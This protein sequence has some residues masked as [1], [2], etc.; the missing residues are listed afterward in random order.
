MWYFLIALVTT[1][2]AWRLNPATN[3]IYIS[4]SAIF[5][6]KSP[7]DIESGRT[8]LEVNRTLFSSLFSLGEVVSQST[9]NA[10]INALAK[11]L[12]TVFAKSFVD[13]YSLA[14]ELVKPIIEAVYFVDKIEAV[15]A[16]RASLYAYINGQVVDAEEEAKSIIFYN[17]P[18]PKLEELSLPFDYP[19]DIFS[20]K[21]LCAVSRN[22]GFYDSNNKGYE[23][24]NN[25][26][27]RIAAGDSG[28]TLS[29]ALDIS[30]LKLS[31][32]MENIRWNEEASRLFSTTSSGLSSLGTSAVGLGSQAFLTFSN[33]DS[34]KNLTGQAQQGLSSLR[35]QA[36]N[37]VTAQSASA[38]TIAGQAIRSSTLNF[39]KW[40]S[41]G[42]W[43]FIDDHVATKP[44][45]D[46]GKQIWRS[47][48]TFFGAGD[49]S[50][51]GVR[52]RKSNRSLV[53]QSALRERTVR[54]MSALTYGR[55]RQCIEALERAGKQNK[56]AVSLS[57]AGNGT[58]ASVAPVKRQYN[59]HRV[60]KTP[61]PSAATRAIDNGVNITDFNFLILLHSCLLHSM[62][63]Y[64][65]RLS[66]PDR[67]NNVS[68]FG[69]VG[70]EGTVAAS[71]S[72]GT[73]WSLYYIVDRMKRSLWMDG[74]GTPSTR[75]GGR[76]AVM[77]GKNA[78]RKVS[79]L[80]T[81]ASTIPTVV[82]GSGK[83]ARRDRF[84]ELFPPALR[85]VFPPVSALT[86][87]SAELPF[88]RERG[89]DA[90]AA[91]VTELNRNRAQVLALTA[92]G[93]G[94]SEELGDR[95]E[96]ILFDRGVGGGMEAEGRVGTG[97]GMSRGVDTMRGGGPAVESGGDRVGVSK[98]GVVRVTTTRL[99]RDTSSDSSPVLVT[100]LCSEKACAQYTYDAGSR[101]VVIAFRGTKDPVD[102]VTDVTF[103]SSGF[104]ASKSTGAPSLA[105]QN[106]STLPNSTASNNRSG[107]VS[108][109]STSSAATL[110]GSTYDISQRKVLSDFVDGELVEMPLLEVVGERGGGGAGAGA[111]VHR[112]F[113]TA[114]QSLQ[115]ELEDQLR[116]LPRDTKLL[117]TGHSM[118]GALAQI[119]AAHFADRDPFLV[120]FAAPAVGNAQFCA[121]INRRVAPYGGL[122]VWNE[123]DVV[124]Y[125]T[126]FVGYEH[127]GMPLKLKQGRGAKELFQRESINAV[128]P[129]L[130]AIA[131]HILFQ[132]GGLVHVFPVLGEQGGGGM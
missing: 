76:T 78:E 24:L 5:S 83:G 131:P 128:S 121:Y 90:G 29:S 94:Y 64:N 40:V 68:S 27:T 98:S 108:P 51:S 56:T 6:D 66:S 35:T 9:S 74:V 63:T 43:P 59:K 123:Y 129:A 73:D 125:L 38:T 36:L 48:S 111:E 112:G 60:L 14:K 21:F 75:E 53:R 116:D 120:T 26:T 46:I 118:G 109:D 95:A 32:R 57:A 31:L 82:N 101:L 122:R 62:A 86:N 3:S 127:A 100:T 42:T 124:P 58:S 132:L 97:K 19:M 84:M 45:Q 37:A 13:R 41:N 30:K 115:A 85:A 11:R 54:H 44:F 92:M 67:F 91:A 33:P 18:L 114:F 89:R 12:G 17:E 102:V 72:N 39:Q 2:A 130:P 126:L 104:P 117:L 1:S 4:G 15:D 71:R 49:R 52:S 34:I 20:S 103:L 105:R 93:L 23:N 87:L 25:E 22:G 107:H 7:L 61:G 110:A 16:E 55:W 50:S 99:P 88:G 81:T 47:T 65:L 106:N 96:T 80:S 8:F 28:A 70:R 77:N 113:L 79:T 69:D 10:E 119:A